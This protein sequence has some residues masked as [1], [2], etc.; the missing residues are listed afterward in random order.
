MKIKNSYDGSNL[1]VS[2]DCQHIED[3]PGLTKGKEWTHGKTGPD[4]LPIHEFVAD[5]P[6][7]GP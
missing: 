2:P 3:R 5:L 4:Q 6:C 7:D 1:A